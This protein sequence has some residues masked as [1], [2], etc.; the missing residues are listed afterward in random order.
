M[1]FQFF[2]IKK[3]R[4]F[5]RPNILL[6]NNLRVFLL[7]YFIN[8]NFECFRVVQCQIGQNFSA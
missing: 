8:N 4:N 1:T 5:S 7:L 3:G 2:D 6:L